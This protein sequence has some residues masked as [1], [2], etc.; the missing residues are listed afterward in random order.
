M[1]DWLSCW[2]GGGGV[3]V[4]GSQPWWVMFMNRLIRAPVSWSCRQG[5]TCNARAFM[6]TCPG[7]DCSGPRLLLSQ[8]LSAVE[9]SCCRAKMDYSSHIF[10]TRTAHP[11]PTRS[12]VCSFPNLHIIQILELRSSVLIRHDGKRFKDD[13]MTYIT[14]DQGG[15]ICFA[16]WHTVGGGHW[17][18]QLSVCEVKALVFGV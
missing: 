17:I 13:N 14:P 2:W 1:S 11:E 6:S 10:P 9:A 5:G 8:W 18:P 3:T 12:P 7:Q 4:R 15:H 16:H